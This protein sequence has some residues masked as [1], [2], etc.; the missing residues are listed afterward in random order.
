LR[1]LARVAVREVVRRVP[2]HR[3]ARIV[4]GPRAGLYVNLTRNARRGMAF[5]L[6]AGGVHVYTTPSGRIVVRVS[7]A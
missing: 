3:Y 2:G 5:A 4:T 7:D 6:L 1:P